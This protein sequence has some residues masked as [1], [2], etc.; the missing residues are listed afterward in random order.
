MKNFKFMSLMLALIACT[1]TFTACGSDDDDEE[2]VSITKE[3][4]AGTWEMTHISGWFYDDD[5]NKRTIDM[6]VNP[7]TLDKL[8][9]ADI[10]D[11]TRYKFTADGKF[12]NYEFYE[13]DETWRPEVVEVPYIINGNTVTINQGNY[14]EETITILSITTTQLVFRQY[15]P[16]EE[17][18]LTVSCKRVN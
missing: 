1:L 14:D 17:Y 8:E 6:D 2:G 12:S 9:E 16:D 7:N 15:D 3:N 10:A 13:K 5:D 18:E 4:L 11:Y